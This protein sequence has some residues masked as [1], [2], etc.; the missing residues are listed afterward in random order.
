MTQ[1]EKIEII[2]ARFAICRT[3]SN[4]LEAGFKCALHK[5]C[6]FGRWRS[7]PQ[8]ECPAGKWKSVNNLEGAAPPAPPALEGGG[9]PPLDKSS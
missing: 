2:K 7:R 5:G 8:S 4:S 6:C 3:C 1:P 9:P